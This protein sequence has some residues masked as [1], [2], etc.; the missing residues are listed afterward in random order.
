MFLF[1]YLFTV[2]SCGMTTAT[3]DGSLPSYTN[4]TVGYYGTNSFDTIDC[5]GPVFASGELVGVCNAV[6]GYTGS[7]IQSCN[8]TY[9]VYYEWYYNDN[10]TGV[11]ENAYGLPITTCEASGDIT[12]M[13]FFPR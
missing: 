5:S 9:C 11:P 1:L 8:S 6:T 3:D 2:F 13:V 4:P 7:E 12:S 10:C